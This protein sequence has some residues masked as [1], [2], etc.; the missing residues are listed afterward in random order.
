MR[1]G[2]M[3]GWVIDL[4]VVLADGATIGTKRRPRKSSA[5]YNVTSP[6]IDFG[7]T[8]V[9]VTEITLNLAIVAQETGVVLVTSPMIHD[10]ASAAAKVI[11][12]G[13]PV[14]AMELMD[15]V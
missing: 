6:F 12:M 7:G 2:T 8:L 9:L 15:D 5:G 13:A 10:A 4:T 1:Y 3:K 11:R 14:G